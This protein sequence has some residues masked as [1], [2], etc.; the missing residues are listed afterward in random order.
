M[1]SIRRN[2]AAI[3]AAVRGKP[4]AKQI[5]LGH[6]IA[7][8]YARF[9]GW[10]FFPREGCCYATILRE[11][12]QRALSHYH[13]WKRTPAPGHLVW[14]R[15]TREQWSLERF[16]LAD[17]ITN[18]QSQFLWH[19]PLRRFHVVG[20]AERYQESVAL[21]GRAFAPLSALPIASANVNPDRQDGKG[22]VVSADLAAEF[23]RRNRRDYELYAEAAVLFERQ[24]A[25]AGKTAAPTRLV[26]GT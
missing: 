2:T 15:F 9:N 3:V 11:P 7:G 4:L 23:E 14:E 17:E 5:Y 26:A 12:L 19:F 25:S 18:L 21:L 6:F 1:S 8:K 20:L 22:Y 16:L 13:C 10:S 24:L